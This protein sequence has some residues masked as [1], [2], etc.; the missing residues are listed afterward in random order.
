MRTEEGE[1][2][3]RIKLNVNTA[4]KAGKWQVLLNGRDQQQND[5]SSYT[6]LVSLKK[7]PKNIAKIL[8]DYICLI[9]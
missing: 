9:T 1:G 2:E 6:S 5:P 4:Q 8:V 7:D 3:R